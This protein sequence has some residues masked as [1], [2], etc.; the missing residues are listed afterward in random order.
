MAFVDRGVW[1]APCVNQSYFLVQM[2][3]RK[4]ALLKGFQH[5]VLYT[6]G[7][8]LKLSV[9]SS[10]PGKKLPYHQETFEV[11]NTKIDWKKCLGPVH[12]AQW[13]IVFL[14]T[15]NNATGIIDCE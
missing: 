5:A 13:Q 6:R 8:W 11:L 14:F 3:G 2:A 9:G 1:I 7:R 10:S 15:W 4:G 12:N